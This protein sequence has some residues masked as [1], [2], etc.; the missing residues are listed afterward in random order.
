MNEKGYAIVPSEYVDGK[1]VENYHIFRAEI[2]RTNNDSI[3]IKIGEETECEKSIICLDKKEF[4]NLKSFNKNAIENIEN[5]IKCF[6]KDKIKFQ[7][8]FYK[9]NISNYNLYSDSEIFYFDNEIKARIFASIVG[10]ELCGTCV[11]TLYADKK[12]NE[13]AN[14]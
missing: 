12:N 3:D 6:E 9:N 4:K 2:T 7:R 10:R 14:L 11:S 5:L 1:N 13:G 8:I